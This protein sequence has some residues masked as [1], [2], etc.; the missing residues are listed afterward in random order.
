MPLHRP[1][2]LEVSV[3]SMTMTRVAPRLIIAICCAVS[4]TI[5]LPIAVA[6]SSVWEIPRM[7]HLSKVVVTLS[8]IFAY[9]LHVNTLGLSLIS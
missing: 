2:R 8:N 5:G 4:L 6:M 3:A 7:G 1:T 9:F